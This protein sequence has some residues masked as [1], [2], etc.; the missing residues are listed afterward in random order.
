MITFEKKSVEDYENAYSYQIVINF[1]YGFERDILEE[2]LSQALDEA[3]KFM[4]KIT[5]GEKKNE[6]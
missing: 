5:K 4:R 1:D 2:H 6:G 3:Q